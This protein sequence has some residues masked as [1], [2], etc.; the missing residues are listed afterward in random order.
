MAFLFEQS[1]NAISALATA[2]KWNAQFLYSVATEGE[3][4]SFLGGSLLGETTIKA[5]KVRLD[6]E[7]P[8]APAATLLGIDALERDSP[9]NTTLDSLVVGEK[10]KTIPRKLRARFSHLVA[11]ECKLHF[12]GVPKATMANSLAVKRWIASRCAEE[13]VVP[14]HVPGVIALAYPLV[15]TPGANEVMEQQILQ[16]DVFG[17]RRAVYEDVSVFPSIPRHILRDYTNIHPWIRLI[18]V[19]VGRPD[20][21][22]FELVK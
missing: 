6:P 5:L 18:R 2:W 13:G 16:S 20:Y 11:T 7:L 14:S 15:F 21:S 8:I 3:A 12:G 1:L 22:G 4:P 9:S 17:E 19:L 10:K